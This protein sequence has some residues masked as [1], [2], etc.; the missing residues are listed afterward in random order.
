MKQP[1]ELWRKSAIQSL[2]DARKEIEAA[3]QPTIIIILTIAEADLLKERPISIYANQTWRWL[4]RVM[5]FA[6]WR[7]SLKDEDEKDKTPA[8]EA[9]EG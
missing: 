1:H 6:A 5:A 9:Q 3:D 8:Q 7:I 2:D 4:Q